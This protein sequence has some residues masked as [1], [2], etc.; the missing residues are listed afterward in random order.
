MF[1]CFIADILQHSN[2]SWNTILQFDGE[3]YNIEFCAILG[4]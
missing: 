2:Y 4:Y 3:A 1:L